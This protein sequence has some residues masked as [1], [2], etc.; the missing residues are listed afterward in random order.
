[1][2]KKWLSDNK[3]YFELTSSILF[4]AAAV[5]VAYAS[6]TVSKQQLLLSEATV[7]PHFYVETALSY[8]SEIKR[9]D[10][11]ELSI[12]NAGGPVSNLG[13]D[14]K[15]FLSINFPVER[16]T[17]GGKRSTIILPLTGYYV[18]QAI[19][20]TPVGKL[21]TYIGHQ[22]NENYMQLKKII[23][24][25]KNHEKYGYVN[26]NLQHIIQIDYLDRS[27]KSDTVFF[28]NKTIVSEER[29]KKLLN[30]AKSE[31]AIDIEKTDIDTLMKKVTNFH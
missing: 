13:I 18:G 2:I 9:Y 19:H 3:I 20:Q 23:H 26:I 11:I 7:K 27:E 30:T 29:V 22:N 10:E 21:V 17:V 31:M 15:S 16:G 1:M 14:L 8:N 25:K 5:L 12:F 4:G 6:Y 28:L 24:T